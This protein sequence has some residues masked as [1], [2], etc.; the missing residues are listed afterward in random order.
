MGKK[1]RI[2]FICGFFDIVHEGH[3]S[4]LKYAKEMCDYLIVAVGTDEFMRKRKNRESILTYEQR[5]EIVSA[6]RYVDEVVPE[7]DL[8][9]LAAYKKYH[10]DV[11][12]VGE[13]HI[14]ERLYIE[15][16]KKLKELGV[17][18]IYVPHIH[19]ISSTEIRAK[20]RNCTDIYTQL[21]DC[22]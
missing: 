3:I 12:F 2:G 14:G 16:T 15:V 1:Y 17:E 8:D 10:F 9:K 21:R 19:K 13:D 20:V 4:I 22:T 6:I 18:T 5:V 11:M 7:N